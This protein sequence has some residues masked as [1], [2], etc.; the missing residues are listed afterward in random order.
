M[1]CRCPHRQ[2]L[3]ACKAAVT[4]P[5]GSGFEYSL[6]WVSDGNPHPSTPTRWRN[7]PR[8]N[9][10]CGPSGRNTG[11]RSLPRVSLRSTLGF[12]PPSLSGRVRYALAVDGVARLARKPCPGRLSARV[13]Y[14]PWHPRS[15]CPDFSPAMVQNESGSFLSSAAGNPERIGA[16]RTLP[17]SVRGDLILEITTRFPAQADAQG[18][19]TVSPRQRR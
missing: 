8:A 12:T 19:S 1:C 3:A 6:P 13:E 2:P 10:S 18:L 5:R 15:N 7:N 11:A 14:N 9:V 17:K 16:L 4:Q